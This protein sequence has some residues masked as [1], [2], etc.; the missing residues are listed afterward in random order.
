[1]TKAKVFLKNISTWYVS[2]LQDL[3]ELILNSLTFDDVYFS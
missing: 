3:R 1:M 2:K